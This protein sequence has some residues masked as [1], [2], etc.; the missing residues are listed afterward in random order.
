M[1]QWRSLATVRVILPFKLA[2]Y[3]AD[4][5]KFMDTESLKHKNSK[6][7]QC[8]EPEAPNHWDASLYWDFKKVQVGPEKLPNWYIYHR[9]DVT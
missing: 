9:F 3:Q 7:F 5:C 2:H 8:A 6:V 4:L 1:N